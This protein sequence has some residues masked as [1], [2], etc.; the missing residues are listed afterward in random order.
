MTMSPPAVDSMSTVLT[1]LIIFGFNLILLHL[2]GS[3]IVR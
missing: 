3:M 1:Y 2:L